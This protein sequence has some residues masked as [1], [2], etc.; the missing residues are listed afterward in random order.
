MQGPDQI[1]VCWIQ[2]SVMSLGFAGRRFALLM[3]TAG[4]ASVRGDK[5]TGIP[6]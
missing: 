5:V 1:E 4:V 3:V 6:G 2:I